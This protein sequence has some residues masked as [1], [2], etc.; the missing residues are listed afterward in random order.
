MFAIHEPRCSPVSSPLPVVVS[1]CEPFVAQILF[2]SARSGSLPHPPA[3][4]SPRLQQEHH[5]H[6]HRLK[7]EGGGDTRNLSP[8]GEHR[9]GEQGD[10]VGSA[11]DQDSSFG[12]LDDGGNNDHDHDDDDSDQDCDHDH[13]DD[14]EHGH[15]HSH[16]SDTDRGH[17]HESKIT[18]KEA[19]LH[20][21]LRLHQHPHPHPHRRPRPPAVRRRAAGN[22]AHAVTANV[23]GT[24]RSH[25]RASL[26]EGAIDRIVHGTRRLVGHPLVSAEGSKGFS[27]SYMFFINIIGACVRCLDGRPIINAFF[28]VVGCFKFV[29]S[30]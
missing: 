27:F 8:E 3:G 11:L 2:A 30:R 21:R 5:Q 17:D 16:G 12:L 29:R 19:V 25:G 14:D 10:V 1:W 26:A 18:D 20:P 6:Q 4:S 7:A 9:G 28:Y 23:G 22:M 24:K 13:D 15:A